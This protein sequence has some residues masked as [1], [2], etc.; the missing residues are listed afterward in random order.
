M[1]SVII[2][3]RFANSLTGPFLNSFYKY[4]SNTSY[5]AGI[6]KGHRPK[7][8]LMEIQCDAYIKH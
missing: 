6:S 8:N 1:G 7:V 4:L 5:V 2:A 3:K